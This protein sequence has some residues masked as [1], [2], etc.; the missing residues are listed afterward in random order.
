MNDIEESIFFPQ[1]FVAF[2]VSLQNCST[3]LLVAT[4]KSQRLVRALSASWGISFYG[5][6]SLLYFPLTIEQIQEV[7]SFRE[8]VAHKIRIE[9]L[10]L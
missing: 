9:C 2:F 3:V 1:C 6:Y 5:R 8:K 4:C 10:C 7:R